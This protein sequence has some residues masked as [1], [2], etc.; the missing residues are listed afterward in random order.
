MRKTQVVEG[1][2][3]IIVHLTK[4]DVS[5]KLEVFYNPLMKLNRDLTILLLNT[6]NKE[7]L[8]IAD[9]LAGSGVRSTRLLTELKKNKIKSLSTND[10]DKKSVELIKKNIELNQEDLICE[11]IEVSQLD[12]NEF[13]LSSSG[14]DYIDIDPFGTPNPF[15]DSAIKRISRKGI[16]AITATDTSSLAGTYPKACLRKYWAKPLRDEHKHEVGLR[17]LIRK[18]Q[19][20]GAQY[21]KALIPLLSYVK[22]HYYRAFFLVEKSKNKTDEIIKKHDY[23]LEAGPLWIG[24]L[25]D[26]KL[27]SK[28]IKDCEEEKTKGFLKTLLSEEEVG[29]VG[30]F[31]IHKLAKNN[32]LEIPRFEKLIEDIKKEGFKVSRTHFNEY[33]LKTNISEKQLIKI[34]K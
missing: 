33:G 23:Y 16:L 8:Q 14:F 27:L 26:K 11:N 20:V 2:T 3:K 17:I 12:A 19:L 29:V 1:K 5:K 24:Q 7:E 9:P 18:I 30:F 13:L 34:M 31:D 10:Y 32:R 22:D 15:L 28:M 4:G 6:I 25:Q 21:E